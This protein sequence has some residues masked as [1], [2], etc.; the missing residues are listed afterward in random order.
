[1]NDI[2]TLI[3]EIK[4]LIAKY[5]E[6]A[7]AFA[8]K[9]YDVIIK[10]C[11]ADKTKGTKCLSIKFNADLETLVTETG[12]ITCFAEGN[13]LYFVK[14]SENGGMKISD[15]YFRIS[16]RSKVEEYKPF[17]G[18]FELKNDGLKNLYYVEAAI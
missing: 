14:S 18:Y 10:E 16:K 6:P 3:A 17:V 1:M 7:A 13:K 11:W 4:D 5:E 2:S 8:P 9:D 12:Y 15:G